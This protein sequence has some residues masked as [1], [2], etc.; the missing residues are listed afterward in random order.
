[1]DTV[2]RTA[3][4]LIELLV[5]IAIIAILIGLLLP[6]VQKVR[7]A[8][9]RL[10]C[11]NNLKQLGL[12]LH[13]FQSTLGR[14]PSGSPQTF[15][16]NSGYLSPQVQLLPYIE[17]DNTYRLFNL[18]LG[19]FHAENLRATSQRPKIFR[20]P[21][22]M[23]RGDDMPMGWTNYHANCGT[24]VQLNGWDGVFG[25]NYV[26]PGTRLPLQRDLRLA[27]IQDGT[28][29]TAAFAEVCN[30]PGT[31]GMPRGERTDCYEYGSPPA[32]NLAQA[33]AAFL[34]G[35]WRARP[36][37]WNGDWRWRGYPWAEGTVWRGWY[38]HL[39]PPNKACW[40]PNDWWL[41]VTP[42]SSYHSGGVNI[43]WCDG[44]VRFVAENVDPD[45]WT[46]AGSR[47]G[48]ETLPLP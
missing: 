23:K 30:G 34:A 44:A 47:A 29:N 20:C 48:G 27:E 33:R 1:M 46:A 28:S 24:W 2:R 8:S 31:S 15:D 45:V 4:T 13:N 11:Q 16:S 18:N 25:P 3:F 32:G 5:V 26:P 9:N 22:E 38:N 35:D 39:L 17:Q 7:E 43:L 10:S 40:R 6:A 19:P 37:P 14:L 42:A 36:I 21:S 12:A 41:L